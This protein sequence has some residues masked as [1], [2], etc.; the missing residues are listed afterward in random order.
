MQR[1]FIF[2]AN[3][4]ALALSQ[5]TFASDI[6]AP[7][8]KNCVQIY[9][10]YAPKT[11][12]YTVRNDVIP[13]QNLLG[14][15]PRFQQ[16]IIPISQ[17]EK[18]QLE[19][20]NASIFLGSNYTNNVPQQFINDFVNTNK[21]VVWIGYH[22]NQL[23]KDDQKKL[24]S[25]AFNEVFNPNWKIK[26]SGGRPGVYNKF[27]YK[28]EMFE[29]C[30]YPYAADSPEFKG[31]Y[32][33]DYDIILVNLLDQKANNN[34]IS[35][36]HFSIGNQKTPFIVRQ[37]NHWY[38]AEN[39]FQFIC[40]GD[41]YFIFAD[42][43]FDILNQSPTDGGKKYALVR[44]E[45]VNPKQDV[46][47]MKIITDLFA[48]LNVPFAISLI[49]TY[50][51]PL[52]IYRPPNYF[53]I[54]DKPEFIKALNYA[55]SHN[56]SFIMHGV[57]HQYD[58]QKNPFSGV[59]AEDFEF[60]DKINNKP[61]TEDSVDYVI[62]H[63]NKGV[64]LMNNQHFKISAWM[65]PHYIASP[66]D[67]ALFGQ[68]FTWNI[69]RGNYTFC[70]ICHLN[71]LPD[72][73]T[74]N[75]GAITPELTLK[76][77]DFFA[78]LQVVKLDT[79]SPQNQIMPYPIYGDYFG[80]RLIPEDLGNI[81]P[82]FNSMVLGIRTVDDILKDAKRYSVLRDV[83]ASFFIHDLMLNLKNDKGIANSP[84]DTSEL[85]RL[86]KTIKDYGYEYIN[87]DQWTTAHLSIPRAPQPIEIY[88]PGYEP[89]C[90]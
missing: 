88:P 27:E 83:W 66:L 33:Y 63:L 69:T 60:W 19:R 52:Y 48:K 54:K 85:E 16:Y 31:H 62:N 11:N 64:T 46:K 79:E 30:L 86:I 50:F 76:R 12:Y 42:V 84:G 89:K 70:K 22:I 87:L 15:F 49:P 77:R 3:I 59:T 14:H 38:V 34:V 25:I 61:I 39:P 9:Y 81:Q 78:N 10:D 6:P 43:L 21:N 68:L 58:H 7:D 2:S 17:Y 51:D 40:E 36:A 53:E 72:S 24:W 35:W 32:T 82:F 47:K 67:D 56:A 4:L 45:D 29:R 5:L 65:T 74:L 55:K 8:A 13:L 75:L 44:Y 71:P 18:G 37:A 80:R 90:N 23:T 41:R 28:G 20:C 1:T 57:T 26:D 73:L